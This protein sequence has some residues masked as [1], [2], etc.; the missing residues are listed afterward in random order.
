MAKLT[1]FFFVWQGKVEPSGGGGERPYSDTPDGFAPA[2][3]ASLNR[4][5]FQ[6]GMGPNEIG[7]AYRPYHEGGR[8]MTYMERMA[9][10]KQV[11]DVSSNFI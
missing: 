5:V 4:P 2:P 8:Q 10:K 11:E 7:E 1:I 9:E 6:P 3:H